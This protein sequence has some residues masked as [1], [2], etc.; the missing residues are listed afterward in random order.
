ML[1]SLK[2]AKEARLRYVTDRVPGIT[3]IRKGPSFVYTAPNGKPIHDAKVLR[4]IRSLVV[5]PAW[6]DVWIC[7]QSNGHLQARGRDARGRKQYRYHSRWRE[8]RDS[9]KYERLIGFGGA[10]P[11]IRRKVQ[12]DLARPGLPRE[13]ILATVVQL[14]ELT[15]SRQE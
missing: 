14:L 2:A 11:R 5:P 3:R 6:N 13:K 15:H 7:P 12:K 1:G 8:V 4:R 10:L 9:N